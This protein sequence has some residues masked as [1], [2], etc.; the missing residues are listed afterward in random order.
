[1]I[2]DILE[3]YYEAVFRY[4]WQR[5]GGFCFLCKAEIIDDFHILRLV[6][7]LN[8]FKEICLVCNACR[9]SKRDRLGG[10][11][12]RLLIIFYLF[13][14]HGGRCGVCKK[15]IRNLEEMSIDHILPVLLGGENKV[16]NFRLAHQRCNRFRGRRGPNYLDSLARMKYILQL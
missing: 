16:D 5:D 2:R 7:E 8:S 14:K 3:E 1:M 9:K 13:D 11:S 15:N 12:C 10:D 4:L 6:K